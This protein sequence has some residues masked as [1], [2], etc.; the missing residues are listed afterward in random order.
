MEGR[1]ERVEPLNRAYDLSFLSSEVEA[2]AG[3]DR[4]MQ[5]CGGVNR[6]THR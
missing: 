6:S 5:Q 1:Q 4:S 3:G 2:V